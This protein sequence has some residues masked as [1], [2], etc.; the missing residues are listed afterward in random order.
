MAEIY[1]W[2][3]AAGGNNASP[4]NGWP[5]MM[6]PASV[7]NTGREMMAVIARYR[8]SAESCTP[9]T[10]TTP[11]AYLLTVPQGITSL[12]DGMR[13]SFCAHVTSPAGA[14]TLSVNGLPAVNLVG[15]RTVVGG[16][17]DINLYAGEILAGYVY[18]VVYLDTEFIILNPTITDQAGVVP[19]DRIPTP[20]TGK[21]APT[22]GGFRISVDPTAAESDTLYFRTTT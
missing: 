13:F 9:T 21:D 3:T 22:V 16:A 2:D 17:P 10:G 12:Q 7:N 19:L 1:D 15:S 4:P 5:E 18:H 14:A 8:E 20:L 11:G 6:T